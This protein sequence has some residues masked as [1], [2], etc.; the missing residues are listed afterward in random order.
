MAQTWLITGG[1]GFLGTNLAN[2]LLSEGVTVTV[3]DNLSRLGSKQNLG[4]LRSCHGPDWH[5]VEADVRD[6]DAVAAAVKETRPD[7][8][9]HLAGQV[10]MTASVEDPRTDF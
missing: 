3:L 10:A 8:V 1:C 5:L 9:A 6:T 2:A 7:V 4:W